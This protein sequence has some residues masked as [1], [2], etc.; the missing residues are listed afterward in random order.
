MKKRAPKTMVAS[1]MET[2]SAA[3]PATT[4]MTAAIIANNAKTIIQPSIFEV[5]G[6]TTV[7]WGP[8]ND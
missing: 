1:F 7:T 8:D 3:G 5:S 6:G 2:G 4:F